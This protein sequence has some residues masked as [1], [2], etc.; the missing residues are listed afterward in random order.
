MMTDTTEISLSNGDTV[1][2]KTI[3]R[4][5]HGLGPQVHF[6]EAV[7]TADGETWKGFGATPDEAVIDLYRT[8]QLDEFAEDEDGVP[9]WIDEASGGGQFP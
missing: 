8:K 6:W 5:D 2:L 4:T 7:L 9:G 1:T 3:G